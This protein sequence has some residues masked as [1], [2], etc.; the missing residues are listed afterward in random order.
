M[1]KV[2]GSPKTRAFRVFWMLEELGVDYEI[3]PAMP[4]SAPS[5]N[6]I[7]R[8]RCRRSLSTARRSSTASP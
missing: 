5:G 6:T 4:R 3:D 8:A 2:I 7:L 1:Y